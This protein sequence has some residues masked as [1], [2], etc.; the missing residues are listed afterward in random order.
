MFNPRHCGLYFSMNQV[1]RARKFRGSDSLRSAWEALLRRR[2]TS[3][4]AQMQQDA[5]LYRLNDDVAAGER[6]LAMLQSSE[7][8]TARGVGTLAQIVNLLLQTQCHELLH[9]HPSFSGRSAWLRDYAQRVEARLEQEEG[10]LHVESAWLNLLRL[11]SAIALEDESRFNRACDLFRESVRKDLH[12]D[13][14]IRRAAEGRRGESLGRMLLTA[15]ALCLCAEAASLAG[16][17]LWQFDVRGVSALTPTPYL[18]YYYWYPERWRWDGEI[19]GN[20]VPQEGDGAPR[21]DEARALFRRHA[22][23]WELA[24]ARSPS[25]DRLE[26]LGELRPVFD[27]QGG[28]PLTLTH[29]AVKERAT[30][31]QGIFGRLRL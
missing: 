24:Q 29:S 30:G 16:E 1:R 4:P 18:L 26:L 5:L 9:D 17:P 31:R 8:T 10:L 13:G 22:G 15:Q 2:P 19:E 28:G 27:V 12:F 21:V 14:Y 6:A 3:Q 11:T 23:L 7:A 20:E 25:S